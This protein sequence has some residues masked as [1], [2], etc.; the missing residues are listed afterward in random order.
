MLRPLQ[1]CLFMAALHGEEQMET[2]IYP[3]VQQVKELRAKRRGSEP[4]SGEE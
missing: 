2:R 4:K 3:S 1:F